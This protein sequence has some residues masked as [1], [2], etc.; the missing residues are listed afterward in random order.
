MIIRRLIVPL[1]AALVIGLAGQAVV[2][3][4]DPAHRGGGAPQLLPHE[5]VRDRV[6]AGINLAEAEGKE[7]YADF[8]DKIEEAVKARQGKPMPAVVTIAIG[9]SPV[10]ADVLYSLASSP[11]ASQ[12]LEKMVD[13]GDMQP[14][15]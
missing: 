10:G 8:A 15:S 4:D 5:A 6:Q 3:R 1:T 11:E 9:S 12:R 14:E 13:A 2:H 7:R